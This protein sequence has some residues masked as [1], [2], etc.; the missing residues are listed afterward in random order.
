MSTQNLDNLAAEAKAFALR[1]QTL[2]LAT[3]DANGVPE[4]SYA[5]YVEQDGCFY[6][7]ISEIARHYAN[8]A[9]AGRCAALFIESE[10]EAKTPFARQ[11]LSLQ[12]SA[13]EVPRDSEPFNTVMALFYAR[14]GKFMDVIGPLQDFHL[15]RLTPT[16]GNYVTGFAR[17]Y[18]LTGDKLA[19]VTHRTDEG[20]RTASA[21]SQTALD[22]ALSGS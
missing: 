9:G 21:A 16:Q 7:Y 15:Y 13:Q 17:A 2:Q 19:Q 14:F 8:L 1:Q 20:H 22:Q 11:R 6:I 5:P 18:R 12:C 3:C 10:A 4:A